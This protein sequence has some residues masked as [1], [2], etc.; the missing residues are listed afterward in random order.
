MGAEM[1]TVFV[2]GATAEAA[3]LTVFNPAASDALREVMQDLAAEERV[4]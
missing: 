3:G 2:N 4:R 1:F